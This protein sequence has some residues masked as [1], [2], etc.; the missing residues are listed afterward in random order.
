[1]PYME[2]ALMKM[3]TKQ[4]LRFLQTFSSLNLFLWI[5]ILINQVTYL[6]VFAFRND[7]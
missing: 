3:K 4:K 5:N 2:I 6:E 7:L 1:M